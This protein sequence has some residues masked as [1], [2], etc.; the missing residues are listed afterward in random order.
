MV[1]RFDLIV[2]GSGP[3]GSA[4]AT[5]AAQGG[6]TVALLDKSAFPRDKLC[7]GGVTGRAERYLDTIFGQP[8]TPDLFR[9]VT[10]LKLLHGGEGMGVIRNAPPFHMTM[11]RDFDTVLHNHASA[12]GAQVFAPVRITQID[13]QDTR[14]HLADGRILQAGFIIGADGVNSAV[15]RSLFGRPFDPAHVSFALEV[16]IPRRSGHFNA[17]EVDLGAAH[18]GYGWVFPKNRSV[19][20]G[21]GGMHHRNPDMKARMQAYLQRHLSP[22]EADAALRQCKGAFLPAGIYRRMPGKGRVLLTGDAAGLVD[23]VTGEGIAWAMR[24]GQLAA[25]ACLKAAG[26]GTPDKAMRHYMAELT[27]IQREIDRARK[28]QQLLF[29]SPQSG[30]MIRTLIKRPEIQR[31]YLRILSGERD[32]QDH[33][34]KMLLSLSLRFGCSLLGRP[35]ADA[36]DRI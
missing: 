34:G 35:G 12:A 9:T 22:E 24:S 16:E 7:G 1:T 2:V 33:S 13:A 29:F 21:V 19:T 32:Y 36:R 27:Y 25:E 23:P 28:A 31:A 4:A 11:R 14:V 26:S 8:I 5:V 6:L 15:A 20:V 10:R 3:A 17:V 18:W 30:A